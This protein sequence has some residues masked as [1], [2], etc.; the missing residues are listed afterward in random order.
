MN[1]LRRIILILSISII[2]VGAVLGLFWL[3]KESFSNT[4]PGNLIPESFILCLK[5]DNLS[6][7]DESIRKKS[8]YWKEFKFS[9]DYP[10]FKKLDNFLEDFDSLKNVDKELESLFYK[11]AYISVH[12]IEGKLQFLASFGSKGINVPDKL[13]ALFS[14]GSTAK[15][16]YQ[17]QSYYQVNIAKRDFISLLFFYE[18]KGA[19]AVST[20]LELLKE[21]I[22][23]VSN[24]IKTF[25]APAYQRIIATAGKNVPAN[26]YLNFEEI[27]KLTGAVLERDLS[28]PLKNLFTASVLDLEVFPNK[29]ILNGFTSFNN[30]KSSS[31]LKYK[32]TGQNEKSL[33]PLFP[34]GLIYFSENKGFP[35]GINSVENSDSEKLFLS[36]FWELAESNLA[37]LICKRGGEYSKYLLVSVISGGNMWDFLSTDAKELLGPDYWPEI[38]EF[39]IGEKAFLFG[40]LNSDRLV[41]AAGL[42]SDTEY[43]SFT[44]Y[45]NTL[46]FAET[47][48]DIKYII[49]QNEL[50]NNLSND[51]SFKGLE[52]NF[53][54]NSNVFLFLRPFDYLELLAMNLKPDAKSFLSKT[55]D[56][57]A[58][59][60]ALSFQSTRAD[61]L[62]YFRVFIN[63]SGV[64]DEK[65]NTVWKRKLDTLAVFKP[66]IVRNNNNMDKEIFIQDVLRNIY[67][68]SSSGDILWKTKC[69][70]PIL[71]EIMQVDYYKNGKLQYLFNTAKRLYLIDR[72]GNSV[73]K[74]PKEFISDAT[75]GISLFD[76][77][78]NGDWRIAVPLANKKIA[79][80][81]RSGNLVSG[82]KFRSA[83]HII[84]Q[85][86][87]FT[88]IADKD[89]ILARDPYQLYFL[90]RQGKKR[91]KPERQIHFS[92][93]N[94]IFI[95]KSEGAGKE[96][97][98]V[99]DERGGVYYFYFNEKV[100]KI[101]DNDFGPDHFFLAEDIVGDRKK[102]FIFTNQNELLVYN[103]DKKLL[104]SATIPENLVIRP[105]VYEFSANDKKIGLVAT[106]TGKI[107]LY[108]S[109]GTLY[110]G[111]PLVGSSLFSISSFPG[112]KGRF[113]LLVSNKDNFLHNYSV[114]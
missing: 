88:R 71:S 102:E 19:F 4:D 50:G 40:N 54:S 52:E 56:S 62:H 16:K 12:H 83:D 113:N 97:A 103:S 112:L 107:Y 23:V 53:A 74:F 48:N 91:I 47:P 37:R 111:F 9:K 41:K 21:S 5:T 3:K 106:K 94:P 79:M 98:I 33:Y 61:S 72:N 22:R 15:S 31:Y 70:G 1:L 18:H 84:N 59:F 34:A 105:I 68:I 51:R 90:D 42:L 38:N 44:V 89:F 43:K 36:R 82:W 17:N 85:S 110:D 69:D 7:L 26:I 49:Q 25:Q 64:R 67:L 92:E 93:K 60:D 95:D 35:S 104:F 32:T 108:N 11:E 46:I 100:V 30:S 73:E 109:D 66:A 10:N 101:M 13:T 29:I 58:K 20:S 96:R 55:K 63:Y 77:D 78:N 45:D 2:L 87:N 86:L 81:D 14:K 80:F 75:A 99:S 114:K 27:S 24:D 8:E 57:W 39:K 76:Y 65:V 6:A 28:L